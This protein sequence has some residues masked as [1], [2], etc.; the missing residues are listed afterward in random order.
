MLPASGAPLLF[1]NLRDGSFR[2]V[3]AEAGLST[4]GQYTAVAVGDFNKDNYPDFFLGQRGQ[5]G[6]LASSDG[7]AR[8]TTAAAAPSTA[9][10]LASQFIDYD[11]DGLLDLVVLTAEGLRLVRNVGSRWDDATGRAF[12]NEPHESNADCRIAG[13][14]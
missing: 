13:V 14:G 5:P 11:N 3:A 9:G 8:F 12:K 2:D 4:P 6:M 10:A 7:R 1:R